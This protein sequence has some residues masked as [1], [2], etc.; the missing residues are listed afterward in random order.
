MKLRHE[1]YLLEK[2]YI[3]AVSYFLCISYTNDVFG[4]FKVLNISF[5][6]LIPQRHGQHFQDTFG[7]QSEIEI[8]DD[9]DWLLFHFGPP[10][11]FEP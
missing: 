3:I 1:T 9:S 11:R 6:N 7:F 4:N 8:M 5:N 10:I 2:Q